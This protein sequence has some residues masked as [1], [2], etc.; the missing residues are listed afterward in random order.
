[1]PRNCDA[2]I[3]RRLGDVSEENWKPEDG[4][5]DL[6]RLREK[7]RAKECGVFELF[8]DDV[9][10]L[11]PSVSLRPPVTTLLCSTSD[12]VMSGG[13]ANIFSPERRR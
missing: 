9:V 1:M 7:D 10:P 5:K 2:N 8:E 12:A 13:D 6:R 4:G 11:L 3:T